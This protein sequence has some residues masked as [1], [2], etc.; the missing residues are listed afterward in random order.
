VLAGKFTVGDQEWAD[1]SPDA[2]DLVKKLLTYD[3]DKRIS[4]LDALNHPWI[5]R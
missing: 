1:V 3:S 2:K 5:K 4:A